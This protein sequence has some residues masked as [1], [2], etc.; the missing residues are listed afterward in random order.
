MIEVQPRRKLT[1]LS[2]AVD[3]HED[4]SYWD[5]DIAVLVAAVI[6]LR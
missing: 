1:E 3:A 4:G 2:A 5:L 6:S